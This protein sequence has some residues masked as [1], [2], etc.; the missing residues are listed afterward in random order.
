MP[1]F[2]SNIN[3]DRNQLQNVV[4]HSGSA[5]PDAAS[6]YTAV[7]GQI[8]Y[9]TDTAQ[10]QLFN[11]SAWEGVQTE[12][13]DGA[14]QFNTALK[15][16]RDAD[17]L[18]DFTTDNQIT[19]R[20]SA[21]NN[22]IFKASGEIEASSLDISGAIDV[23]GTSA[24]A[25][26]TAT[27]G[28]FSGILKT[29]DTTAATNT[30]DGSLQTDG[31]LSV[32]AD[33]VIGDDL[34][35][36]SDAAVLSLGAGKDVTIT[37]DNGTGGTLASAGNF[38]VDST[39]GT[40]T[41]DGNSGVA[42]AG[43]SSEIDV[44]TT[45]AL[46]LNSGAYTLNSAANTTT[47]SGALAINV[48][49]A[50]S[51]ISI[52]T[53]HTA[54]V[55]FHLDA[56][57]NAGSEVQIDA[58]ILDIDVTA[59]ITIDGTTLSI[60]GTD[61]SNL[62]VTGSGK[63]LLL[64][65]AGGGTQELK[66]SS[67]GT[68]VSAIN[69]DATAG[70]VDVDAVKDIALTTTGAT[71]EIQL[72]S[73]HTAGRAVFIDGNA[74]AGSIVDIDAGILDIDAIGA[75]GIT[76]GGDV[77]IESNAGFAV[78][79]SGTVVVDGTA[80]SIDGT[81]DSNLTVTGS[82]KDLNLVVAGGGTQELRLL[83]A[84]TGNSALDLTTS[85]GGIDINS[86]DMITVDAA[87][88]IVVTTTSADGHISLV[89]AH[90]AGLA[91]HLDGNANSGS[92]VQVDAGVLDV[93]VTGRADI[94]TTQLLLNSAGGLSIVSAVDS[95]ATAG[96]S[97]ILASNDEAV[98]ADNHRLG[99]IEF[100]GAEDTNN[101]LTTGAKIEA[102]CDAEWSAS[103]NGASLLFYTTDANAAQGVAL[104]LDSDQKATFAA[105]VAIAGDLV[106]TGTT[107]TNN[108]ETVSTS[109][110]VIFEGSA[111]DGHDATL[112]SV[113]ASSDKTYTLP[114]TTGFIG[115]FTT[116]PGTTNVTATTAELNALDLGSTAVGNA[117]ASKAV[118]LDSSKDFVGLNSIRSDNF[119]IGGHTINDVDLAGEFV[120]SAEHLLTSAAALDKFHVLNADTTGTATNA[121]HVLITDNESTDEECEITFVEGAA[122]GTAQRGLEADG[123]LTY[124]P[125]SGTLSS[126]V[127][128]GN[129]AVGGHTFD[130]IDITSEFVDADAHIMSSKAIGARFSLKAG[131]TSITTLG[132]IGTGV[133]NGTKIADAYLSDNTAHLSGSQT[134]TG[135]KT[136]NSFKGTAGATVTNILDE[137]A[138]GSDSAT[139]LATQ[140]SIKAY[141]D[142]NTAADR[143][144]VL[145]LN[146]SVSGVASSDNITYAVTHSLSSRNVMVEV[147]RNGANS[148]DFRTVYVDVTRTSDDIVTVVFGSARTAGDYTVM[149][150]KIG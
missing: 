12:T 33:A 141:V 147:I 72:I 113:V 23:D 59:G 135:T 150:Q 48:S 27:T 108:V 52:T 37:H 53:A 39:G 25:A 58:G 30:T 93:N 66:L 137:D 90:T 120:D 51:D 123:D 116:D 146:N 11:G 148:G 76:G 14:L 103:E 124:N 79:V 101:T 57:A 126:T 145:V 64:E 28:V 78:D 34:I 88:E 69:I 104:T 140:Q 41:L 31:G 132:T 43:G 60:D 46:D 22:V 144:V 17:N 138:M 105:D 129:Y 9:D 122:G 56:N 1:L 5:K 128:K 85:A 149:I 49:G 119:V 136:L 121:L 10:L 55:A 44:T 106:V 134:F 86:A 18:L 68:A 84:G 54:G 20:V 95:S 87:D 80:L 89:S 29:D 98:M 13:A 71:G 42:I 38:V 2:N 111:A 8:F 109:S 73:A 62:N 112:K 130:D 47:A 133:W 107:T 96:G 32:A 45:G 91:I 7:A 114:N 81:D 97:L 6:G 125:S 139:A 102:I 63:H 94:N 131:S 21:G 75:V 4:I 110:G 74:N 70:G 16:G 115:I 61:D 127:F 3:L 67:A 40:L 99:V 82:A 92:I 24:L 83:S 15:I 77:T 36:I 118:V 100:Q 26:V 142:A 35:L 65:V 143:E 117:I 19:F 50:A